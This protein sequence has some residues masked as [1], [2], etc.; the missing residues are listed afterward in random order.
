MKNSQNFLI[1][2]KYIYKFIYELVMESNQYKI[3]IWNKSIMNDAAKLLSK[4]S[5]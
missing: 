1:S 2:H 3:N 5:F 4:V